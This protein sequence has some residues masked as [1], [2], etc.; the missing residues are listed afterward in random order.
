MTIQSA[1]SLV[2]IV[3]LWA[4]AGVFAVAPHAQAGVIQI[5]G[6]ELLGATHHESFDAAAP[7][8]A[9]GTQFSANGLTFET[10]S[11]AGVAIVHTSQ[12]N[13]GMSGNYLYMGLKG[14]C[15]LSW[16]LDAVSLHFA[17]TVAELS[18]T[19]FNRAANMG[20]TLQALLDGNVVA[21]LVLNG[22]NNF[23]RGN[24]RISGSDFNELRF[25][26]NGPTTNYFALDNLRWNDAAVAPTSVPEP[27]SLAL[28][29]LALAGIGSWRRA[30]TRRA[31]CGAA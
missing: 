19:G 29:T 6:G 3:A 27:S 7:G 24:V 14:A 10:L 5:N 25:T 28:A 17:S 30:G 8:V 9:A 21:S 23:E 12:C 13:N 31:S 1:L 4:T 11:G 20:F 16:A 22:T 2:R 15:A 18:W 26:E